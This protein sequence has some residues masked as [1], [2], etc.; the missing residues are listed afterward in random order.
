[1][2]ASKFYHSLHITQLKVMATL[3]GEPLFQEYAD[4]WTAYTR[5][6]WNTRRA[7]AMKALFKV[8]YY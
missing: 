7:F 8:C 2:L 1:M 6:V 5:S 4:K 3:T